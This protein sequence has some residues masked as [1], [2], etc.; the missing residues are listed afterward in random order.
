MNSSQLTSLLL[1]NS[2]DQFYIEYREHLFNHTSHGIIALARLGANRERIERFIR[3]YLP[4]LEE[5]DLHKD[6]D[7]KV[8]DCAG[9]LG[10]RK[11]YYALVEDYKRQL[12]GKFGGSLEDTIADHFP[13]LF[14]GLLGSALHAIIHLGYA[15]AARN[16]Q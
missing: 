7:V 2:T 8:V 16:S 10:A 4:R 12:D 1:R 11:A 6:D 3:W 5:R 15:Y 9:L 14:P 13:K